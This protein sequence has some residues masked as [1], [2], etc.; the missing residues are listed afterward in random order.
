M[1]NT[2]G[3]PFADYFRREP[4]ARPSAPCWTAWRPGC[5]GRRL[6]RPVH[7]CPPGQRGRP[8]HPPYRGRPGAYPVRCVPGP[9]H[10]QLHRSG[11]PKPEHPQRGLCPHSGSAAP[12]PRRLYRLRQVPWL[13]G[14]P[15]RG[16]FFRPDHRRA[17]RRGRPSCC[18][19]WKPQA[20]GS[21]PTWP[22]VPVC[23]TPPLPRMTPMPCCT[24][25][26]CAASRAGV[27]EPEA[28]S[29]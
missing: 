21:A 15:G 11:D 16:A 18:P 12:G 25:R 13:A 23:R 6:Y 22:S 3:A 28:V 5:G 24:M 4:T 1:K 27:L 26:P 29:G 17:G 7:G 19:H 2:F 20:S 8:V 14:Q 10:R 9:H